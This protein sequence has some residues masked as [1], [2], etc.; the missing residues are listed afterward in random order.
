MSNTAVPDDA[1]LDAAAFEAEAM[2]GAA[3]SSLAET[4]PSLKRTASSMDDNA[5]PIKRQRRDPGR[6]ASLQ[7]RTADQLEL[8]TKIAREN[9]ENPSQA[10]DACEWKLES[11][12]LR[13]LDTANQKPTRV[14]TPV[15][16]LTMFFNDDSVSIRLTSP[17][18][19]GQ[20]SPWVASVVDMFGPKLV[21]KI[22]EPGVAA[23]MVK[24]PKIKSFKL[25]KG[26]PQ[27]MEALKKDLQSPPGER[28][29]LMTNM[30]QQRNGRA[31]ADD[32]DADGPPEWWINL[33]K[34]RYSRRRADGS[35]RTGDVSCGVPPEIAE[36]FADKMD[37]PV[38]KHFQD[39]KDVD[40]NPFPV[41]AADGTPL[42]CWQFLAAV[43]MPTRTGGY[44]GAAV[45]QVHL[46]GASCTFLKEYN[47][48]KLTL[49]NNGVTVFGLPSYGEAQAEP[50][51]QKNLDMY[52]ALAASGM[53]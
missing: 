38:V 13:L 32:P 1:E 5:S 27:L 51:K 46:G 15:G 39:N 17:R 11:S 35:P 22:C 41:S 44:W 53:A 24:G 37:H 18:G 28:P 4:T 7:P 42:T 47:L 14:V 10:P 40:L 50:V 33:C 2:G 45:M 52:A 19:N 31:P 12:R 6:S 36:A 26:I 21:D 43:S 3:S 16:E 9:G 49:W 34:T 25:K 8:L 30:C 48:L 20:E 23:D 29:S